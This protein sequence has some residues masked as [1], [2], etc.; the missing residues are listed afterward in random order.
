MKKYLLVLILAQQLYSQIFAP[1]PQSMKVDNKK[2]ALGE[3]LFIDPII[4]KDNT[5]SCATCHPLENYGVDGLQFSFGIN[6]DQGTRNTPTIYNSFFNFRQMWDGRAKTLQEQVLLPMTNKHEMGET[7][8]NVVLKLKENKKYNFLFNEIYEDGVSIENLKDVLAEFQKQLITP[9]SK[10]DRYLN[11]EKILTQE[12]M[13]GYK[14]FINKG[15]ASCHNGINIG[16]NNFQRLGY[17]KPDNKVEDE[18]LG[19][20]KITKIEADKNVFKV[21]SLRN[22]AMTAPYLHDGRIKSLHMVVE[23]MSKYQLG[24]KLKDEEI[25]DIVAF[26]KTLTGKLP[27]D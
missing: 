21:P 2:V 26:L 9:N 7:I 18:D 4:S 27:N 22:V 17:F 10:F 11:G 25:D 13:N 20:Y 14:L 24:T 5:I 8:D 12:E 23:L 19:R 16:G 6:G 15:C 1:L 3:K